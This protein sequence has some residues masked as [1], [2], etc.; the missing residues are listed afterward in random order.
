M[1]LFILIC[2]GKKHAVVSCTREHGFF[3][4]HYGFIPVVKGE[5]FVLDKTTWSSLFLSLS[6]SL[7]LSDSTVPKHLHPK[8]QSMAQ[9]FITTSKVEREL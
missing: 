2:I 1:A 5:D 8:L 6:L 4:E 3:Y 7:S 9:E